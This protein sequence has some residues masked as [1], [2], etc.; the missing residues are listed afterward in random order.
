MP[1]YY[2]T[3]SQKELAEIKQFKVLITAP[4]LN[5]PSTPLNFTSLLMCED[6]ND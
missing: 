4:T 1:K 6:E 5:G 2:I 3:F